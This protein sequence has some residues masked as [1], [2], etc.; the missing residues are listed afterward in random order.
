MMSIVKTVGLVPEVVPVVAMEMAP[1]MTSGLGSPDLVIHLSEDTMAGSSV[2]TGMKKKHAKKPASGKNVD[3]EL[4]PLRP[5]GIGSL[6]SAEDQQL[7]EAPELIRQREF[8]TV[9]PAGPEKTAKTAGR[10]CDN[11]G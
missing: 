9:V 4:G 8:G 7:V 1:P 11:E 6:T 3:H 10:N 2:P 5:L